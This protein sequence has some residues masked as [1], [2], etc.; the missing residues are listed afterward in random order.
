MTGPSLL[1]FFNKTNHYPQIF[2]LEFLTRRPSALSVGSPGR[3]WSGCKNGQQRLW[4]LDLSQSSVCLLIIVRWLCE[5]ERGTKKISLSVSTW[6]AGRRVGCGNGWQL[7]RRIPVSLHSSTVTPAQGH[8]KGNGSPMHHSAVLNIWQGSCQLQVSY[9]LSRVR[10]F[11]NL[12]YFLHK[13]GWAP[14]CGWYH[15]ELSNSWRDLENIICGE[16][17]DDLW[18][19]WA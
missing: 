9:D 16:S 3:Y 12:S 18:R 2:Y 19:T 7:D 4:A 17:E 13:A 15:W 8:N 11:F 10:K 1:L 14:G 5:R 6:R